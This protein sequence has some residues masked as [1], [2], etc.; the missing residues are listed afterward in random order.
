MLPVEACDSTLTQRISDF[1]CSA[2]GA[3][4]FTEGRGVMMACMCGPGGGHSY[5]E[6]PRGH[7]IALIRRPSEFLLF[8]P[9]LGVYSI[10][11]VR[12]AISL[13]VLLL[14]DGYNKRAMH[15]DDHWLLFAKTSEL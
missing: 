3:P 15:L 7:V 8:D 14:I 11:S 1:V 9:N 5:I 2:I 12:K 10:K 6:Q 4:S 13:L